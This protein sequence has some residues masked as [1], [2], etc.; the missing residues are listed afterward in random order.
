V[1]QALEQR[2]SHPEQ[3]ESAIA[4]FTTEVSH[5]LTHEE[6]DALPLI[7]AAMSPAEWSKAL[8]EIRG[9]IADALRAAPDFFP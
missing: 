8:A 6:K 1:D 9:S 2:H 3:L 4:A 5:H 7:L